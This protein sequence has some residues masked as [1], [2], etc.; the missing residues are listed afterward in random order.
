MSNRLRFFYL[1]YLSKPVSDRLIYR[2]IP[3][4]KVLK[5]V[6]VGVGRGVRAERMIEAAGFSSPAGQVQYTGIDVFEAR[7]ASDG[8]GL[9]LKTAHRLLKATGARIR[10]LP[11]DP[12][13]AL[14]RA[15]NTLMGT[16]LVVISADQDAH[17]LARAW[18]YLPR[19]LHP[20]SLVYWEER[21]PGSHEA[22]LRL[23]PLAE[24]AGLAAARSREAA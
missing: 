19:M 5:I 23:V 12:F 17:S 21:L 22:V 16:D 11:G 8:P 18:F 14:A 2:A 1:S 6:E 13:S 10:L 9:T 4:R 7:S 20:R 24:I 3:R 15:A